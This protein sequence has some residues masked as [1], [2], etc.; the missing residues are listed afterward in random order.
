[1]KKLFILTNLLLAS[2]SMPKEHIMPEVELPKSWDKKEVA[3]NEL[4]A[5]YWQKFNDPTL[6]DLII[7]A[8]E[9]N[10]DILLAMNNILKAKAALGYSE[11]KNFPEIG[12][13]ANIQ[14][15]KYSQEQSIFKI[16]NAFDFFN[17]NGSLN[18]EFDLWG[19]VSASNEAARAELLAASYNQKT[20]TLITQSL[21]AKSY[22]NL[23]NLKK[24]IEI[25]K[26]IIDLH[27]KE[28][29]LVEKRLKAG[30]IDLE[31]L[32]TIKASISFFEAN[33]PIL[34]HEL[35]NQEYSLSILLGYSPKMLV[36]DVINK[37]MDIEKIASPAIVLNLPSELLL[38]RPDLM[39]AEQN[40]IA[41]NA[42]IK[43]ARAEY[44]PTISLN[45]LIGQQSNALSN[46]LKSD[47]YNWQITGG[48][49]L[50][51][52]NLKKID[53][54][55]KLAE[56]RKEEA[57]IKYQNTISTAFKEVL[58]SLSDCKRS[59]ESYIK[60][61]NNELNIEKAKDLTEK[62]HVAGYDDYLS[63]INA[64]VSYYKAKLETINAYKKRL[65]SSVELFKALGGE[66]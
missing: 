58:T 45:S 50:P 43:V 15:F 41:N 33:L 62:R 52:F 53:A 31:Q 37:N 14:S 55:V 22:F 24:K 20:V 49:T 60:I 61:K 35:K 46:V 12:I 25:T 6:N 28:L 23:L 10:T 36:E 59:N 4:S 9:N 65:D 57:I 56:L 48:F 38:K 42:Q 64:K 18:Y 30:Y 27:K 66:D 32:H 29:D 11:G 34:K 51:I 7:E 40:I 17:I 13:G 63:V 2:C 47:A 5:S 26:T 3:S 21:I 39:E 19:K 1:M 44:F 8:K 16:P 54:N